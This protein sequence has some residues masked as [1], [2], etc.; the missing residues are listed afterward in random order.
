MQIAHG[1]VLVI[2]GM[3]VTMHS[4]FPA[5]IALSRLRWSAIQPNR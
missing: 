3:M 1:S 5:N 2:H 4:R